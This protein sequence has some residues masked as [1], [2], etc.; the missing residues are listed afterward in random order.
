[1]VSVFLLVLVYISLRDLGLVYI[2]ACGLKSDGFL[3]L[4]SRQNACAALHKGFPEIH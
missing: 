2:L 3:H 1:M 4:F